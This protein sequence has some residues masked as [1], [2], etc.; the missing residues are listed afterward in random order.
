MFY[1]FFFSEK[2]L[3]QLEKQRYDGWYNNLAHPDW[4]A[5]GEFTSLFIPESLLLF[6]IDIKAKDQTSKSYTM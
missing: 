6:I 3:S 4:G 5:T 1:L 2:I